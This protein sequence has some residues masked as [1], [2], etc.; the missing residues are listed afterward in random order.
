[1]TAGQLA[2]ALVVWPLASAALYLLRE[3]GRRAHTTIRNRRNP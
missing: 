3:A 2:L 1:M